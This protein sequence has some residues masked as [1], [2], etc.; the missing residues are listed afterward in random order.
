MHYKQIESIYKKFSKKIV[1]M[2]PLLFQY[3]PSAN[4]FQRDIPFL[5]TWIYEDNPVRYQFKKVL[6]GS[7]IDVINV[8]GLFTPA[9]IKQM[10]DRTKILL[11]IHQTKT[12]HTAE[13]LRILPALLRG[14]LVISETSPLSHAIPYHEYIFWSPIDDIPQLAKE[15]ASNYDRYFERVHGNSSNLRNIISGMRGKA[16]RDLSTAMN[17]AVERRRRQ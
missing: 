14:V 13:E 12:Y 2:P 6:N 16:A 15:I 7:G 3:E 10:F 4:P 8:N 5:T 1:Y 11:N 17:H 9:D